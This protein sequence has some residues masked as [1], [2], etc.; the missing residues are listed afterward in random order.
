[1]TIKFKSEL[2]ARYEAE[3]FSGNLFNLLPEDHDCFIFHQLMQE[4]DTSAIEATF[5]TI[6]QHGYHPRK[7][8]SILIYGYTHG[9]FSSRQ[10]E[11]HCNQDLAFMYM[12]GAD[13]PN[14]RVLS[15]FRKNNAD[16]FKAC[17]KQSV[18][19]AIKL[20]MVS[21]GHIS[22]DGTK[23][24]ANSSKYK[25]MSYKHMKEKES[26][27]TAEIAA[28]IDQANSC[29]TEEDVDANSEEE[30]N[31]KIAELK[32]KQ[33]RLESIL[34]AKDALEEREEALNPG[35][36]IADNKQI[37]FSDTEARI[38][39]K[40]GAFDYAYNAQASVDSDHQIIV[41]Q[42]ITQNANDQKEVAPALASIVENVGKLPDAM[43]LDNGYASGTNLEALDKSDMDAYVAVSRGE[44][45]HKYGLDESKRSLVKADFIYNEE[46]DCF[47]CPGS[48]YLT[49]QHEYKNGNRVYQGKRS[50]CESCSFFT[51]CCKSK[52]GEARTIN[53]D[54]FE[55]HR[56][57][58]RELM[59]Q[60]HAK[61]MYKK[62]KT[63]VEPVFGHIKN[64]GFRGFS[65]RG[66][67]K[68]AGEFSL[69]CAAYNLKKIVKVKA[70]GVI[71]LNSA[72]MAA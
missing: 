53:T 52:K 62:R 10:L 34:K 69:V 64:G 15:D 63:I 60:S 37:S 43:S 38:M 67:D 31:A 1:M 4:I 66:K 36:E 26:A 17:F 54:C 9:V 8:I 6:G 14:F 13:C 39:G 42:H 33:E 51:R 23:L 25:A 65:V 30:I 70:A 59:S 45:V 56:R 61:E 20:K 12:A 35:V 19:L 44:K 58:M 40:K 57:A 46:D 21:L 28:L 3:H 32:L 2:K 18:E 71:C 7:I 16:F 55:S 22:L 27:L 68:V 24:K 49:L 29:D 72:K 5:S 50:A 47:L 41:G 11:Q 48:Q